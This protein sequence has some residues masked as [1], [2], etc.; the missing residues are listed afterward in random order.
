MAGRIED[1]VLIG[2]CESA[3]LVGRDGSI[4]WLC[5]PRFDSDACFAALLGTKEHGRFRI[6]PLP[7]GGITW[8][9]AVHESPYGRIESS[10][11][12]DGDGLK[13]DVEVPPGTSAEIVLPDGRRFEMPPGTNRYA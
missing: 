6:A 2:D 8:A 9:R 12:I 13:L 10:W 1:Y 11:R 7:G 4:D 5:W 3:A